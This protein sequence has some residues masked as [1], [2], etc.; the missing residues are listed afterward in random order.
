M[1]NYDLTK[2][3]AGWRFKRFSRKAYKYL[4]DQQDLCENRYGIGKYERW[5]YDQETGLLTF[6]NSGIPLLEIEYESVGSISKETNTWLWAWANPHLEEKV[7]EEIIQIR[8]LGE[9]RKFLRLTKSKWYAD[10]YDGWEMTAIS[11]Y[12]LK[13][14]GAYRVPTEKTFSFMIFKEIKDLRKK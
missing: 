14:K 12:L 11:A 8:E 9:K 2:P 5:F 7:K 6:S 4:F 3:K 1:M 13:G 10:E